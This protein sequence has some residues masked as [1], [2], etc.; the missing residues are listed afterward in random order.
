MEFHTL[1]SRYS[2]LSTDESMEE[3]ADPSSKT[4]SWIITERHTSPKSGDKLSLDAEIMSSK[5]SWTN[6]LLRSSTILA[7]VSWCSKCTVSSLWSSHICC[8]YVILGAG[9]THAQSAH[10]PS[11]AAWRIQ[12]LSIFFLRSVT[13]SRLSSPLR[14]NF[15]KERKK[16]PK[17][18]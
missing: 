1:C 18:P 7:K 13:M 15:N 8:T 17:G 12:S 16:A 11:V 2:R 6:T 9:V 4:W 3:V 10:Q 14:S 5:S